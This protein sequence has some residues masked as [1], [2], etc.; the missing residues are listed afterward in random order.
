M[1][2]T[3]RAFVTGKVQGVGFRYQTKT[4]AISL[5]LVG[6]A[7]NLEDG[8]VEVCVTGEEQNIQSLFD[9]IKNIG[10]QFARVDKVLIEPARLKEFNQFAI[11]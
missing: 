2:V 7:M 8:S 3:Q 6:Y 5:N 10:P 11:L 4:H 1:K 9:W